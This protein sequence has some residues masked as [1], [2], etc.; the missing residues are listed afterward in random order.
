MIEYRRK[1]PL[2]ERVALGSK[3]LIPRGP[4]LMELIHFHIGY[5]CT[6]FIQF[7][8]AHYVNVAIL[9]GSGKGSHESPCS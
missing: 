3:V 1:I 9:L 2:K 7:V 5:F 8:E 6:A 4:G